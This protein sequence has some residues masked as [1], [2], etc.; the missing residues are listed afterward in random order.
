MLFTPLRIL[1]FNEI[2]IS[3]VSV[4]ISSQYT[5]VQI[6]E[7]QEKYMINLYLYRTF[8]MLRKYITIQMK[9]RLI[10]TLIQEPYP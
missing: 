2:E 6:L 8:L 10:L 4:F 7:F 5:L 1:H 9:Y 3:T